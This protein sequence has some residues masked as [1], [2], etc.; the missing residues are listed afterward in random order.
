MRER[1]YHFAVRGERTSQRPD[2]AAEFNQPRQLVGDVLRDVGHDVRVK[3][4]QFALDFLEGA[5]DRE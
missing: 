2:R 3:L 5:E 4:F 1:D